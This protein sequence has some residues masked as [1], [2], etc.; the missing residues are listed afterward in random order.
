MAEFKVYVLMAKSGATYVGQS[1]NLENRIKKH[2]R[3]SSKATRLEED[4]RVVYEE[5][6]PSRAM[7]LKREKFLKT[8]D[9]RRVLKNSILT[10]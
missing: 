9:G 7:A 4:W 8:G 2:N 3:H 5:S 6:F 1:G 10:S